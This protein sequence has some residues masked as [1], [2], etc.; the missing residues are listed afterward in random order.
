MIIRMI[1]A[2]AAL[3]LS[4]CAQP[5][6][7]SLPAPPEAVAPDSVV[8]VDWQAADSAEK[9]ATISGEW[10][11]ICMMQK[12]AC[13]VTYKDAGKACTD[14]SQCSGRCIT[15]GTGAKPDAPATGIC[16]TVSDPCGCFQTVENGKAGYPLCAD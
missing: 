2:A 3:L 11:P 15:A 4:A 5:A 6:M 7:T 10:R 1:L 12:P 9:C 8:K 13:V 14:S 16:T